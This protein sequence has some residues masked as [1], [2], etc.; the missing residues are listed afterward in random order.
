VSID[1][2]HDF[3]R[4]GPALIEAC[5]SGVLKG[6]PQ[7]EATALHGILG[8]VV[9]AI[10]PHTEACDAA[11]LVTLLVEVG[12]YIGRG[13]HV[14]VES[15]RHG[16]AVF[17]VLVGESARGRKGVA[18][19][20][21]Q[22]VMRYVD[23]GNLWSDNCIASGFG[24]GE[25]VVEDLDNGKRGDARLLVEEREFAGLLTA[26]SRDG[27]LLSAVLRNGWDGQPL[28]NRVKGTKLLA[29]DYHLSAIG[30]ITRPELERLLTSTEQS[31]GFANRFLWAHTYRARR[32]PHGGEAVA[33]GEVGKRLADKVTAARQLGQVS[34]TRAARKRWE[35][36]YDA[37]ADAEL[38]GIVAVLTNRAEAYVRRLALIYT[39]LDGCRQT[40]VVHLEAA[41]ALWGYCEASVLH[42][43]GDATGDRDVDRLVAAV[44]QAGAEG[45]SVAEAHE[46]VFAKH[47]AVGPIVARAVGHGL[48]CI[49]RVRTGGRTREVLFAL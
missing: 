21:I 8:E 5:R 11:L 15:D 34:M 9:A 17:A 13:P 35:A 46:V 37:I 18:A 27:S 26:A 28:R 10:S 12:S 25:K 45:L 20:R 40:D 16:C 3:T 7:L 38:P 23:T 1:D 30:H 41:W 29:T 2:G 24:S 42:I 44:R 32:L 31:N 49:E 36:I 22:A 14:M 48:L 47:K 39:V 43:W 19:G 33:L 4:L 6:V